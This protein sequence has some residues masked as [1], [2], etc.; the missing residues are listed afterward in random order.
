MLIDRLLDVSSENEHF[1]MHNE[2]DFCAENNKIPFIDVLWEIFY[3]QIHL[4]SFSAQKQTK[5]NQNIRCQNGWWNAVKKL[6]IQ[7][8]SEA[9]RMWRYEYTA[10]KAFDTMV[11]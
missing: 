6:K 1:F 5:Y 10:L 7:I 8:W 9:D 4:M 2:N 3:A 11:T